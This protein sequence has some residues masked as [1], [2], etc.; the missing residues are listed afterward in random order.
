MSRLLALTAIFA[1]L[2]I[3]ASAADPAPTPD[4]HGVQVTDKAGDNTESTTGQ[5]GS[6]S[7]DLIAGFMTFD[8]ASGKIGANVQV[9]NLTAGEIDAPYDAISWEFGFSVDGKARYVRA[10]EDR[11]GIVKYTWGEPR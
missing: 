11:T 5:T 1:A 9:A 4:C 7:S 10:Y 8:P 2:A 3:P 6:P